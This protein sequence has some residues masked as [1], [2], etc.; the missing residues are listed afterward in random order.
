MILETTYKN[1]GSNEMISQGNN[2]KDF[3]WINTSLSYTV[4]GVG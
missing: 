4:A 2:C 1:I 3:E